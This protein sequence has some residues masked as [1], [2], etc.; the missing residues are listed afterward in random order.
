MVCKA[1]RDHGVTA[2]I[3]VHLKVSPV[4][5]AINDFIDAGAL[6][7]TFHTEATNH[8]DRS[9]PLIKNGGCKAGLIFNPATSLEYASF[10]KYKECQPWLWLA[11][12]H[13]RDTRE[14]TGGTEVH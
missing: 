14:G 2:P 5:A 3:D 8:I 9:L 1:L 12:I 7:I 13:P 6:Y 4:D 11:V 10:V